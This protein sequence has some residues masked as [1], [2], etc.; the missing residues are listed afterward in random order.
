M[1]FQKLNE[2]LQPRGRKSS[3]NLVPIIERFFEIKPELHTIYQLDNR[4]GSVTT[5]IKK[6]KETYITYAGR[7]LRVYDYVIF[8]KT[9]KNENTKLALRQELPKAEPKR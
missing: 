5:L 1:K 8:P 4:L 9:N 7:K 2:K 3:I 6:S